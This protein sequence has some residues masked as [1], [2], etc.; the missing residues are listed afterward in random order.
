MKLVKSKNSNIQL[1]NMIKCYSKIFESSMHVNTLI[2]QH[3][4]QQK[5]WKR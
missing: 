3:Q 2:Q 5:E 4:Q 1:N